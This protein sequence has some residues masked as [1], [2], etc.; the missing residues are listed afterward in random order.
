MNS[1]NVTPREEANH[2]AAVAEP[3]HQRSRTASSQ[4]ETPGE[5]IES[6]KKRN[7]LLQQEIN[8]LKLSVSGGCD[9]SL[10]LLQ[11]GQSVSMESSSNLQE[12]ESSSATTQSAELALK[13][14]CEG[15]KT[16]L[17]H[18][19]VCPISQSSCSLA[20]CLLFTYLHVVIS[21]IL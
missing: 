14:E 17:T 3:R 5:E 9:S 11:T 2:S 19:K 7:K 15:L 12:G 1:Q 6:L 16:Q 18:S 8:Q 13:H 20:V 10:Q 21:N 4:F